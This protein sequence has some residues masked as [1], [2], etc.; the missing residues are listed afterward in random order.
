M[1]ERLPIELDHF[2]TADLLHPEEEFAEWS[3]EGLT[4]ELNYADI[5]WVINLDDF[6]LR[7]PEKMPHPFLFQERI[8]GLKKLRMVQQQLEGFCPIQIPKV[9][10]LS[11]ILFE[12]FLEQGKIPEEIVQTLKPQIDEM[13][14]ASP[15]QALAV[16]RAFYVEGK[17]RPEGPTYNNRK[18]SDEVIEAI[19][20]MF[21]YARDKGYQKAQ[22]A[23]ITA[24]IQEW[25][26]PPELKAPITTET[27]LP[28]GGDARII[29]QPAADGTL[30]IQV[31]GVLGDN[32]SLDI[33]GA[34]IDTWTVICKP[35]GDLQIVREDIIQSKPS[36][37][38]QRDSVPEGLNAKQSGKDA[39]WEVPLPTGCQNQQ[40]LP[41]LEVLRAAQV[42]KTLY[43]LEGPHRVEFSLGS[44]PSND[45]ENPR[46]GIVLN[47]A[48]PS[49][50]VPVTKEREE[51][52]HGE[53]DIVVES[54][55]DINSL[56]HLARRGIKPR[57][58][59]HLHPDLVGKRNAFADSVI[60]G[61]LEINYPLDITY[62]ATETEHYIRQMAAGS[63]HRLFPVGTQR[64][65][66][67][68]RVRIIRENGVYV[69]VNETLV[70]KPTSLISLTEA[71]RRDMAKIEQLGGK[72]M[73]CCQLLERNYPVPLSF[74]LTR[75]FF[76]AVVKANN[77]MS[78]YEQIPHVKS[79]KELTKLFAAIQAGI[80]RLPP[81]EW[82]NARDTLTAN[83]RLATSNGHDITLA[84]RS[85]ATTEDKA[86]FSGAG[87]L[88]SKL[89]VPLKGTALY[90]AVRDVIKS[91]FT[92][93]V[94]ERLWQAGDLRKGLLATHA[95]PV[96]IQEM[97]ES[98]V[99]GTVFGKEL[100]GEKREG[101]TIIEAQ[102]GVGGV[103]DGLGKRPTIL[104]K[105]NRALGA[106]EIIRYANLSGGQSFTLTEQQYEDHNMGNTPRSQALLYYSEAAALIKTIQALGYQLGGTYDV[107]WAIGRGSISNL[108][109]T[110]LVQARPL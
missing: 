99:S 32:A 90:H 84:V 27:I 87:M 110:W 29:G 20:S 38:L 101:I 43:D 49:Q 65:G 25:S 7:S 107:E 64:I 47:E 80:K 48:L 40:A 14:A 8:V 3:E 82:E 45:P 26:D 56:R 58:I 71:V 51:L 73:G 18:T 88:E 52:V 44:Y 94:A 54:K 102:L 2:L 83:A 96:L 42:V 95:V 70:G 89:H 63:R 23:E 61:L 104:I 53:I 85:S 69:L 62:N 76:M 13:L 103:V 109:Q 11:P 72:S 31:R 28:A 97:V 86:D 39:F 24:F 9:T 79:Q 91:G 78:L 17:N 34:Q 60:N 81:Q 57:L 92:K 67:G 4:G 108:T 55:K 30:T 105:F 6:Q 1:V 15:T 93:G 59:V 98:Q 21:A 35:N 68:H 10:I 100:T 46:Y 74:A 5:P 36:F 75:D 41:T 66:K 22:N 77:L 16:R 50:I 19:G 106:F 33:D 37:Y 12:I